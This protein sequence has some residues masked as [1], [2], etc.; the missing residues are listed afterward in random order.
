[1]VEEHLPTQASQH[2]IPFLNFTPR[3]FIDCGPGSGV[4]A[5]EIREAW[6]K[7]K[8]LG[9]EPS[10]IGYEAAKTLFP[11]GGR[12]RLLNVGVWDTDCTLTLSKPDDLLHSTFRTF[13]YPV[14][15]VEVTVR[16]LDSLDRELGPFYDTLL[17]IDIEG[18]EERALLGAKWLLKRGTIKAV[19][20]EVNDETAEVLHDLLASHGFSKLRTY[21]D[22]GNGHSR[23][24]LWL[25]NG[26]KV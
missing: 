5:R 21:F 20:I 11:T 9:L 26:S 10:L 17:W 23:D 18:S 16:S 12:S 19:N 4:E 2:V 14:K 15:S 25:L 13:N 22:Q 3:W 7:V 6:P 1:M 8:L 24:E